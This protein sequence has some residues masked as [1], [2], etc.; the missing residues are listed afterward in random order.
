VI[1]I[2]EAYQQI[3]T[4]LAARLGHPAVSGLYLPAPVADETFR[5]EFG[6]VL[7]ADGSVGPF[8]VSMG[9]LLRKLWQRHPQPAQLRSDATTLLQGFAD[10][11]IARR[12]LALGTYNALSVALFYRVGFVPP[13]RAG[14]AG[15]NDVP[16]GSSVGMVGY[17]RPLVDRLTAQGCNV[18]VLELCP[19][20]VEDR[21]G[22]SC[23]SDPSELTGC[24]RVLCTASA[25]INDSL[26]GLLAVL[27]RRV[28]IELVGPSGS[29]VPD[30]L[31]ARGVSAV[32]GSLFGS[33]AKLIQHLARGEPW[34]G[35]AHK[36]QLD[37]VS[38]PGL[39]RLLEE[40]SDGQAE[41]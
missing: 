3:G 10:G 27:P 35:V 39:P 23:C 1:P 37:A 26:E 15:S 41:T 14:N 32:G 24:D 31:F 38:Y 30:P 20:R 36:Y 12:A 33:Q 6:F 28:R 17:F 25:L 8:Y 16:A 40:L 19:E 34:G 21:E 11:D 7:L 13:E 29:G 18:R 22:V 2:N 5:D 4:Q 9:D